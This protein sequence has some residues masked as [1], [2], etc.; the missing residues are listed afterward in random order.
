MLGEVLKEKLKDNYFSNISDLI[1]SNY[2]LF[3][4]YNFSESEIE[5]ISTALKSFLLQ[6]NFSFDESATEVNR[7]NRNE[8]QLEENYNDSDNQDDNSSC[9]FIATKSG[10][11]VKK[12]SQTDSFSS[13]FKAQVE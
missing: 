8:S 13:G 12:R 11:S 5:S 2:E 3:S 1:F 7:C 6:K 10:F 4:Y 9:S